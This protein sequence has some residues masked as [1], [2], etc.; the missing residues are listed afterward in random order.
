MR[1]KEEHRQV[2]AA[3]QLTIPRYSDNGK[4]NQGAR[5][6][7]GAAG[8]AQGKRRRRFY[9]IKARRGTTMASEEPGREHQSTPPLRCFQV[10]CGDVGQALFFT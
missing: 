1:L 5:A 3:D 7:N 10:S 4:V 2:E 8:R 9:E 6:E